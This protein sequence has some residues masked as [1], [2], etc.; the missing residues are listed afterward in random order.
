MKENT[1][2]I[3]LGVLIV[4]LVAMTVAY[5]ALTTNLQINGTATVSTTRWD[6]HFANVAVDTTNTNIPSTDY[7]LGTLDSTALPS[8]GAT[9]T[10]ISGLTATLKKPGDKLVVNFDIVNAGTI[11]ATVSAFNKHITKGNTVVATDTSDTNDV[12][13]YTITCGT[14]GSLNGDLNKANGN[15]PTS[16]SCTLTVQYLVDTGSAQQ[17]STTP[18]TDQTAGTEAATYTFDANW[19]Y[20]QK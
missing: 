18:G 1:K 8:A 19:T 9:G 15:T 12:V 6:I 20:V 3:L 16:T 5:A 14:G 10:A 13:S 11:D 17:S 4:G 2:N 7:S